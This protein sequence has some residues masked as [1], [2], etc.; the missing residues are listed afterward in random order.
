[1][2]G[3]GRLLRR[4]VFWAVLLTIAFLGALVTQATP[5]L[6][7]NEEWRWHARPPAPDVRGRS[8]LGVIVLVTYL[9]ISIAWIDG[10]DSGL[11]S[12]R[13]EWAILGFL[14]VMAP[15]IQIAM[16]Y[17]RYPYPLEFYL[18]RTIG[19]HNGFWQT[20]VAIDSVGS[21]LRTYPD[22]MRTTEFVHLMT[23]PP[24]GVLYIWLWRQA[25]QLL[26]GVGRIVAQVFR[27]Y[28]CSA[29]W[30]VRLENAQIASA[31]A[32]MT[33]PLLSGLPI[34]P[35]YLLGKRI[36]SSK[37]AFRAAALYVM[38]PS[39]TVFTMRWDQI[40]PLFLCLSLYCLHRGLEER[41]S[42][43]FFVSGLSLSVASFMS[44]GNLTIAVAI[45]AYGLFR[46][47]SVRPGDRWQWLQDT[48][49]S[50]V[51]LAF[52]SAAVW[53]VYQ[54]ACGVSIWDVFSTSMRTHLYLGRSYWLWIGW[55]LYDFLTFLGIPI[56][57]FFVAESGRAW[58]AVR[59]DGGGVTDESLLALAIGVA[60][61]VVNLTGV[62]RG[63]V[64]RL[65]LL[66]M[67]VACLIAAVRLTRRDSRLEFALVLKLVAAQVLFFALFVRMDAT[68]L[69]RFEPRRPNTTPPTPEKHAAAEFGDKIALIGYELE[70]QVVAPGE[71]AHITLY[72]HTLQQP[73][74]PYTVFTHLLNEEGQLHGQQDNMP[75]QDSLPTT[76]WQPGEFVEDRYAI[77]VSPDAP[78]GRYDV[79]VGMYYLPSGERLP[80]TV[81]S[82]RQGDSLSLGSIQVRPPVGP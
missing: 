19:Y 82:E 31:M 53:L 6:L 25:F 47:L 69:E 2:C 63:E 64:G 20:A 78:S 40:Y 54:A 1:M 52:G 24:G 48:W 65:W 23:H 55:N 67:P 14:I 41:Q 29:L 43:F 11:P 50:W 59:K 12:R 22:L 79:Q 27:A 76:C 17:I 4:P 32:Q 46:V 18:Y 60:L 73:E 9:V 57:V 80:I 66:W 30:F 38:V 26:P 37:A 16:K 51:W 49:R 34:L 56:A 42:R 3:L 33:I 13:R 39:L 21:S 15:V 62:V 28:H 10:A 75:V 71:V 7:G 36:S 44:L 8:W 58:R 68:G 61:L 45:G 72:W 5:F 35:L 70:P 74:L 81:E 77:T